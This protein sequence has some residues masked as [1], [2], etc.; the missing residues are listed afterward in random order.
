MTNENP[1]EFE[2]NQNVDSFE[3]FFDEHIPTLMLYVRAGEG[4]LWHTMKD[5]K[6]FYL[7]HN[8]TSGK[9]EKVEIKRIEYD[10]ADAKKYKKQFSTK[11]RLHLIKEKNGKK[12]KVIVQSGTDTWFTKS[13]VP[14]LFAL[15]QAKTLDQPI[16]LGV[17][18]SDPENNV[19]FG[20]IKQNGQSIKSEELELKDEQELIELVEIIRLALTDN[21]E[22][23]P[24]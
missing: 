14:R 20:Y 15:Y 2:A 17:Y 10:E 6:P 24:F 8:A 9:I 23:I 16:Q 18:K 3:E 22:E 7:P 19:V 13:I 5:N 12:K 11:F 1:Q 21:L 4:G